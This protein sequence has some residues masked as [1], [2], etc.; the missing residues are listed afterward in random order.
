MR[1]RRY[2]LK[3][4]VPLVGDSWSF[5]CR[6]PN[7]ANGSDV[8]QGHS[9]LHS[10]NKLHM[11][12]LIY[13]YGCFPASQT[14]YGAALCVMLQGAQ[15]P[16]AVPV[17]R[18]PYAVHE[19]LRVR[20]LFQTVASENQGTAN[21]SHSGGPANGCCRAHSRRRPRPPPP[22]ESKGF[23]Y[24]FTRYPYMPYHYITPTPLHHYADHYAST[25]SGAAVVPWALGPRNVSSMTLPYQAGLGNVMIL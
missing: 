7:E 22:N 2:K 4:L 16:Y 10:V 11:A 5:L 15:L 9:E 8:G 24:R 20:H 17:R 25:N 14:K 12:N 23:R 18:T 1:A 19:P 3:R 13:T 21:N 6:T